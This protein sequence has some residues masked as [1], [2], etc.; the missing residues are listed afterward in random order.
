MEPIQPWHS[1]AVTYAAGHTSHRQWVLY[2]SAG[3]CSGAPGPWDDLSCF[4][5]T[6]FVAAEQIR[7]QSNWLQSLGPGAAT[8]LP[9]ES[10]ERGRFE[11]AS[12]WRV[13]GNGTMALLTINIVIITFHFWHTSFFLRGV[14]LAELSNN[15]FKWKNVTFGVKTYSDSSYI[16]SGGQRPLTPMIYAPCVALTAGEDGNGRAGLARLVTSVVRHHPE[17]VR[18]TTWRRRPQ[19]RLP[20]G[21]QP[22]DQRHPPA[23]RAILYGVVEYRL[24]AVFDPRRAPSDQ[25]LSVGQ[26]QGGQVDRRPQ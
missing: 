6:G 14:K 13:E 8:S 9:D 11:T 7:H 12:D 17:P 25:D 5:F 22:S 3:Q 1:S 15:S 4:H 21:G 10:A 23:D 2:F 19:E 18:Y 26:S 20:V 16:F 24:A